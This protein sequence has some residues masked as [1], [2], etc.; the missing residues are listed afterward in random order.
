M[1]ISWKVS[2]GGSWP[3][4]T[5][6]PGSPASSASPGTDPSCG[7]RRSSGFAFSVTGRPSG[8]RSA[9][10]AAAVSSSP[11]AGTVR[12]A[13]TLSGTADPCSSPASP[14]GNPSCCARRAASCARA[15][16]WASSS[17]FSAFSRSF[18]EGSSG[19]L[20]GASS[21]PR[22]GPLFRPPAPGGLH[23]RL[24]RAASGG[25]FRPA[26]SGVPPGRRR[27]LPERGARLRPASRVLSRPGLHRA[28]PRVGARRSLD[29]FQR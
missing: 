19:P 12:L 17:A 23:V 27:P 2:D 22:T 7:A 15:R 3:S 6:A 28:L 10:S 13:V 11:P 1:R 4:A 20:P 16:L 18:R 25:P 29:V 5:K 14:G 21:F 8:A 9:R 26:P 24:L